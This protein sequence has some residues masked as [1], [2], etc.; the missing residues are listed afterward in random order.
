MIRPCRATIFD[1]IAPA[2][3]E[4]VL[5]VAGFLLGLLPLFLEVALRLLFVE[6]AFEGAAAGFGAAF[7]PLFLGAAF[8]AVLAVL[9][10]LAAFGFLPPNFALQL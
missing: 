9:T 6:V 4:A 1:L 5:T 10:F 7:L 8:L 2:P 3:V